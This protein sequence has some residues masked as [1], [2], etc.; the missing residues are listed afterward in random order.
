MVAAGYGHYFTLTLNGEPLSLQLPATIRLPHAFLVETYQGCE[1]R[2]GFAAD[3]PHAS[4]LYL[5]FF[6]QI[7]AVP[8]ERTEERADVFQARW[9]WGHEAGQA[10][11][12]DQ[13][14]PAGRAVDAYLK[15]RNTPPFQLEA[16]V[17][18]GIIRDAQWQAFLTWFGTA[19]TT[20]VNDPT[21]VPTVE[22]LLAA[23]D[24]AP[25]D[26]AETSRYVLYAPTRSLIPRPTTYTAARTIPWSMDRGRCTGARNWQAN[27]F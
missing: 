19:L 13:A 20:S 17:W 23:S 21:R 6:G 9:G 18:R 8:L 15:V 7:I 16:P 1:V 22:E 26:F 27:S 12:A 2:I 3:R 10:G 5:D 14:R 11:R 4:R 25:G 24:F